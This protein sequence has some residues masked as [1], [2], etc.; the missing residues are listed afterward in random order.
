M[1]GKVMTAVFCI[2]IFTACTSEP[3]ESM[4]VPRYVVVPTPLPPQP[5]VWEWDSAEWNSGE[6]NSGEWNSAF[7]P[8]SQMPSWDV[9]HDPIHGFGLALPA[10]WYIDPPERHNV[11]THL[12]IANYQPTI[13]ET[14][15]PRPPSLLKLTVSAVSVSPDVAT[16]SWLQATFTH[17]TAFQ[18]KHVGRYGG[19]SVLVDEQYELVVRVTPELIVRLQTADS[20]AWSHPDIQAILQSLAAPRDEVVLPAPNPE[21]PI[22]TTNFCQGMVNLYTGP[23]T[24]FEYVGVL[25]PEKAFTV[26]GRSHDQQWVKLDFPDAPDGIAW[27]YAPTTIV[28]AGT[29]SPMN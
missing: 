1:L 28:T 15:C 23:G 10:S 29:V 17:L 7:Y 14:S 12:T 2:L 13:A 22:I 6:W 16:D 11:Q 18:E 26:I 5:V 8:A 21:S 24:H 27:A 25:T 19:Y 9:Y 4:P 20:A 3:I